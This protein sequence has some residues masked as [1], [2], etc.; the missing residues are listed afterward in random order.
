MN[1]NEINDELIVDLA[2]FFK[3]F[4]DSSRL[5]ILNELCKGNVSVNT[6]AET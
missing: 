6:L 2:D 3:N 4:S 5:R 1:N